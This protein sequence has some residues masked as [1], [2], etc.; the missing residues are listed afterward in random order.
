MTRPFTGPGNRKSV[1][2][3]AV[4][5]F[6]L[7]TLFCRIDG[8]AAAGCGLPGKPVWV[9]FKVLRPAILL[10]DWQ[11]VSACLCEKA[12]LLMHLLQIV[13]SIWPLLRVLYGWAW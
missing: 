13:A 6:L 12:T 11:A 2:A 5:G 3:A 10:A 7:A 9:V 4:V 8:A 1:V